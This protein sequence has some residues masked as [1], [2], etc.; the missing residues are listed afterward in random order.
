MEKEKEIKEASEIKRKLKEAGLDDLLDKLVY[1]PQT[2]ILGAEGTKRKFISKEEKEQAKKY[3]RKV[4][5]E[6]TTFVPIIQCYQIRYMDE[7][8]NPNNGEFSVS[9]EPTNFSAEFYVYR[10]IFDQI[11]DKGQTQG[12]KQYVKVGLSHEV[13][14]CYLYELEGTRRDIERAASL[15]GFLVATILDNKGV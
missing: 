15:I 4:L 11:P 12:F 10:S 5:A 2:P 13:G 7:E 9:Y 3:I 14:H 6:I 1:V 8:T